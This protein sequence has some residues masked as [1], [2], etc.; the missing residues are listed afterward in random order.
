MQHAHTGVSHI[1]S[2]S[3]SALTW[4]YFRRCGGAIGIYFLVKR[5]SL[6]YLYG[7]N[8]TFA[9]SPFL[10][11][12][13][14]VD[15]LLRYVWLAELYALALNNPAGRRGRRQYLHSARWEDIRKTW[16]AHGVPT[17][18]ARKLESTVDSGGWETL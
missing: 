15:Q 4:R 16:L 11:V 6:L 17:L 7:G 12:H 1:S 3:T 14:E 13:G 9:P 10:D 2:I 5:C 8:G 18:V